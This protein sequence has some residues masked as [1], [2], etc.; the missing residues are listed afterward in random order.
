MEVRFH[1]RL[2]SP[3]RPAEDFSAS[4]S[5]TGLYGDCQQLLDYRQ[6][7]H[8]RHHRLRQSHGITQRDLYGT[9]NC[10]GGRRIPGRA[11][12]LYSRNRQRIKRSGGA[13]SI[14]AAPSPLNFI[15][16]IG[17]GIPTTQQQQVFL[18]GSGNYTAT[19][20][21]SGGTW[22]T[23]SNATGTL[24]SSFF[25]VY[26]NATG[27]AAGTYNGAVT[28][29]NTGTSQTS[30]VSVSLVVTGSTVVYST[31]ADLVFNYMRA[32]PAPRSSKP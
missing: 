21:Q 15:Y 4:V 6:P 2:L 3:V 30:V 7:T 11:G 10:H 14:T 8:Y 13:S 1:N 23:V 29:T 28:F 9:L 24:P 20:S 31:P 16:Q 27:L 25:Y 19:V 12:E 5:G 32:L 22:L 26:A 17:S 18:A